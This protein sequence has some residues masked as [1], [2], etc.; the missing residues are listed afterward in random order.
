MSTWL[1][2]T[3]DSINVEFHPIIDQYA[4]VL[5]RMIV[6]DIDAWLGFTID[7]RM[8][9]AKKV[10]VG[11]MTADELIDEAM[12][13][14]A[15]IGDLNATMLDRRVKQTQFVEQLAQVGM[16]LLCAYISMKV[17]VPI[18]SIGIRGQ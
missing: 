8:D 9:A 1:D 15:N 10:M 2:K 5:M 11:Y 18:T 7:H 14:A 3:R 17:G 13:I 12:L 4:P 16:A 6:E